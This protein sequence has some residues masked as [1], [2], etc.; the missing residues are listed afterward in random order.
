MAVSDPRYSLRRELFSA[1][2]QQ[3]CCS[4]FKILKEI[5]KEGTH[6]GRYQHRRHHSF[7][8]AD[9]SSMVLLVSTCWSEW[10]LMSDYYPVCSLTGHFESSA[11]VVLECWNCSVP[12]FGRGERCSVN[13]ISNSQI[14]AGVEQKENTVRI[15]DASEVHNRE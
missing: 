2:G 14:V 12:N 5:G 3:R 11:L 10:P 6:S 4:K 7:S 15:A 13:Y 1:S 9:L 8:V